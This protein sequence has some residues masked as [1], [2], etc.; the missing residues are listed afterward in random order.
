MKIMATEVLVSVE[1]YL[2]TSYH[3]DCDYLDGEVVERNLGEKQHSRTRREILFFLGSHYTR[4][5]EQLLPEQ[6]VQVRANRYR[7]PDICIIAAEAADQ[8]IITTPPDLCIEILSPE[9]T[10]TG[11]LDRIKDYFHMGVPTCW[12]IDPVN[13]A[14]WTATPGHLQEPPDGILRANGIE[15]PLAEVL[16][17]S[18]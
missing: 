10:M 18:K 4:L 2:R 13:R 16:E 14:G 8:E 17:Q 15:M 9:D 1:D 6:R 5:R 12:I 3:P 11:T 7:I